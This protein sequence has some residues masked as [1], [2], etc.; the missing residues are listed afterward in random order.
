ML[1]KIENYKLYDVLFQH[2]KAIRI[3]TVLQQ[4]HQWSKLQYF[5]LLVFW[6]VRQLYQE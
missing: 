3:L 2:L 5:V 6:L 1:K 4:R